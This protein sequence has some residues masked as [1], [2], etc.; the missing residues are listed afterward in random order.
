MRAG[1]CA[2]ERG[3]TIRLDTSKKGGEMKQQLVK[4]KR[5]EK[6]VTTQKDNPQEG[7]LSDELQERIA[8]RAY[9]L[10]LERGCREGCDVEDWVD[11][12]REILTVPRG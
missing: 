6:A 4:G 8:K 9:E 12:E 11:A 3:S 1:P 2:V 5:D 7:A 10:Y